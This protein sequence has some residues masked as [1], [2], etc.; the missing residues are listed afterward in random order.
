MQQSA[1][2]DKRARR[3]RRTHFA[4]LLVSN[5][6]HRITDIRTLC[7][8]SLL[9]EQGNTWTFHALSH[10]FIYIFMFLIRRAWAFF[11]TGDDGTE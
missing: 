10:L 7:P 8:G 6:I 1:P 3:E 4:F 2:R 5:N 11:L 9:S